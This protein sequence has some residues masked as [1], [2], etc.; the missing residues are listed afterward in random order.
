MVTI[1]KIDTPVLIL[2]F[3]SRMVD[4]EVRASALVLQPLNLCF[5]YSPWSGADKMSMHKGAENI[6]IHLPM[7]K[8]V[9]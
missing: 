1:Y 9:S 6:S 8:Y 2:V 3:F 4:D 5:F 7:H